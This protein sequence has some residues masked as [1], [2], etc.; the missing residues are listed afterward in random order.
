MTVARKWLLS[1]GTF[2]LVAPIGLM[3]ALVALHWLGAMNAWAFPLI[4]VG[5]F[6]GFGGTSCLIMAQF[7]RSRPRAIGGSA[8]YRWRRRLAG[9]LVLLFFSL[10]TPA[11]LLSDIEAL[12]NNIPAKKQLVVSP[13]AGHHQLIG[14]D[15]PLWDNS[16]NNF[17]KGI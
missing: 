14:V 7:I 10:N 15:R 9:I 11:Y 4:H 17:L 13:D 3:I 2:T 6:C 1:I 16:I 8:N 12:V 5:V